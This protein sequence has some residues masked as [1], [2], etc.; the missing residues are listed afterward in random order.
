MG[1]KP[2][3]LC[4]AS[5][6]G[7]AERDSCNRGRVPGLISREQSGDSAFA[8]ILLMASP[9]SELC[10]RVSGLAAV[11]FGAQAAATPSGREAEGVS[12]IPSEL[13]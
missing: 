8:K 3:L 13:S 11:S 1:P 9:A 7:A 10:Y 2:G 6:A 12:T 4:M 5:S